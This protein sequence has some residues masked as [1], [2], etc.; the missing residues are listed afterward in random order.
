LS[1]A[2]ANLAIEQQRVARVARVAHEAAAGAKR[3]LQVSAD[4]QLA[5]YNLGLAFRSKGYYAE[6]LR[7][8][9]A[10]LARGED[11]DLV[12]Q[13]MAEVHLLMRQPKEA[14]AL[15][16]ELLARHAH[17]PKLW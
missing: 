13:A 4:A 1:R 3:E 17:S 9:G 5:R 11:A 16:H 7:E 10:A 6:A 8:Y 15:Y 14:L 12:R 2:H